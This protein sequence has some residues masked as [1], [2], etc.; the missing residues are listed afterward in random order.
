MLHDGNPGSYASLTLKAFNGRIFV[1]FLKVCMEALSNQLPHDPEV[2]MATLAT[3]AMV[4]W[5]HLQETS[6]RFL[7]PETLGCQDF[8]AVSW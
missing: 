2:K 8:K 7:S 4:R 6:P 3:Q 1:A 5:F